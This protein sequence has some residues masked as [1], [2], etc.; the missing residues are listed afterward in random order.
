M[1][2]MYLVINGHRVHNNNYNDNK[3]R[4]V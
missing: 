3:N 1:D 2:M 4:F